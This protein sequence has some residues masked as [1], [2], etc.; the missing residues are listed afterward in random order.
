[1]N[2]YSLVEKTAIKHKNRLALAVRKDNGQYRN[3][4]YDEFLTT[5]NDY[6]QRLMDAGIKKGDRVALIA[7]NAPETVIAF[8]S[9][10]SVECTAVMLDPSLMQ[11]D[12]IDLIAFSDVRGIM[13]SQKARGS[14]PD[15]ETFSVPT[16]DIF[17][18]CK[19]FDGDLNQ[20][21][22]DYPPTPD[23]DTEVA[24]ILFSSGTT[25]TMKGVMLRHEGI[26]FGVQQNMEIYGLNEKDRTLAVVPVFHIYGF[27]SNMMMP[28]LSGGSICFLESIAD[29]NLQRAFVEYKP[30]IF[31]CVPR[32]FDLFKNKIEDT[33]SSKGKLVSRIFNTLLT[34][35]F[36]IREKSGINLGQYLFRSVHNV[37]GGNIRGF[38]SSGAPTGYD[39][40]RFYFSLGF[41][42]F[43]IYGMTETNTPACGT[44]F[45][46]FS[47]DN[48]GKAY[49][50][51]GISIKDHDEHGHGEIIIKVP[52]IMKGYFRDQ[53]TTRAAFTEDG[54]FLTGDTGYLNSEGALVI[55]GRKKET[56]V[57]ATGK[58]VAPF[59]L[60][61]HFKNLAGVSDF[62]VCGV[63]K[64]ENSCDEIHAFVVKDRLCGKS[65]DEVESGIMAIGARLPQQMRI[66]RIHF[67]EDIPKTSLQKPKRYVLK[68]MALSANA[69][70]PFA[71]NA[72]NA[73]AGDDVYD[74]TLEMVSHIIDRLNFSGNSFTEKTR[75][76]DD[77]GFDS[78]S[79][80]EFCLTVEKKTGKDIS[81]IIKPNITIGEIV[82]FLEDGESSAQEIKTITHAY[83]RSKGFIESVLFAFLKPVLKFLYRYEIAGL[84]NIPRNGSYIL[85]PNH[86]THIDSLWVLTH[87]PKDHFTKFCCMAKKE[88]TENILGR[89]MLRVVGGIPVDRFGNSGPAFRKCLEQIRKGAVLLIHP[90]GTRTDTGD[91]MEF[92][93]GAAKLAIDSGCPIVPVRIEGGYDIFPKD[94]LLPKVM[95]VEKGSIGRHGVRISFGTPITP[96]NHDTESLTSELRQRI[97]A[98]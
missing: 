5:I 39:I 92:K 26:K 21:T 95:K 11:N 31:C 77:L 18:Q 55:T 53:E 56:I 87:L 70:K 81:H 25:S 17:N 68:E 59:D 71:A 72:V 38:M 23:P 86:Q 47:F 32:V 65:N 4:T 40:S 43:T 12:L 78:L 15:S 30:T 69:D 33:L 13:M 46:Y 45:K 3:Y 88:H 66:A 37:F 29:D 63:R 98:L 58:K 8:M 10:L 41:N 73:H 83:P 42:L 93:N 61:K 51:I 85:C 76:I 2:V 52:S 14:F 96:E 9:I 75:L 34:S 36:H 91:L 1:M 57:L 97:V 35:C 64:Q 6:A 28:M 48:D 79:I 22:P 80:I 94:S 24:A 49:P 27:M 82:N 19:A 89:T 16:F 67:V 44:H 50:N 84:E 60:E 20:L 62:V 74:N 7:E 90:E 54:W